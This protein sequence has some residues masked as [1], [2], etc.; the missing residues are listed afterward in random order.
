MATLMNWIYTPTGEIDWRWVITAAVA[1]YAAALSTFR[2][3]HAFISRR[4]DI[5]VTL[6]TSIVVLDGKDHATPHIQVRVNNHGSVD[7]SFDS[8]CA[9]LQPQGSDTHLLLWKPL[10]SVT[11]WPYT[12]SPGASFYI[13]GATLS[14]R[15]NLE[16]QHLDSSTK[17]R[18]VVVDAIGR[19]FVSEWKTLPK[20]H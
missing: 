10:S 19:K 3:V 5:R 12:L 7:V 15:E 4:P 1:A 16:L 8:T 13:M 9:S 6:S 11:E 20:P 17:V 2:E 14:V 18:A